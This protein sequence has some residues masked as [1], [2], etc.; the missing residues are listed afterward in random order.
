MIEFKSAIV[1]ELGD[2]VCWCANL[3]DEEIEEI[4]TNHIEWRKTCIEC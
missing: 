3:S 1:D 2:I 4:L